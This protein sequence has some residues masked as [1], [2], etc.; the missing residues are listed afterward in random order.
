M[1][2]GMP[3][4]RTWPPHHQ[5][6][7]EDCRRPCHR[8]SAPG[9]SPRGRMLWL[10]AHGVNGAFTVGGETAARHV[11]QR[12]ARVMLRRRC[13][14]CDADIS[15]RYWNAIYCQPCYRL[16]KDARGRRKEPRH[17]VQCGVDISARDYRARLC[18]GCADQNNLRAQRTW[19]ARLDVQAMRR[20]YHKAYRNDPE[21][22]RRRHAYK[23]LPAVKRAGRIGRQRRRAIE[24]QRLGHVS[25]DILQVLVAAQHGRCAFCGLRFTNRTRRAVLDHYYPLNPRPGG[26]PGW[27]DDG[28][29]QALCEPCNLRKSNKDPLAFARENGWL[30]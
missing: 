1:V 18:H 8:R 5:H 4:V 3:Q 19:A 11:V 17:C 30:L 6:G 22:K 10:A 25:P 16:G 28:N 7:P 29:L 12:G 20:E 2:G 23:R 27:H 24:V 15:G 21:I 14:R 26:V 13:R 9:D